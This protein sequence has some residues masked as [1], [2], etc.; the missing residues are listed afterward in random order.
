MS[1]P[2]PDAHPRKELIRRLGSSSF[3][4]WFGYVANVSLVIWLVSHA[5][6]GGHARLEL[7]EL[8]AYAT[9][10]LLAWTLAEYLLV[11]STEMPARVDLI[12]AP[13][14]TSLN[15]LGVK[16]VG[17]TGVLPMAAAIASAIEDALAPFGVR[18]DKVPVSPQEIMAKIGGEK[19]TLRA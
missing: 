8:L 7:A 14:R 11:T 1:R 12:D 4:Y 19:R 6:A 17:E 18:I 15:E 16:G 10:G 3:N 9:A 2:S 5:F 13:T